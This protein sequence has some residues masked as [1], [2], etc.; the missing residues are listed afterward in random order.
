MGGVILTIKEIYKGQ[1]IRNELGIPLEAQ[2][3]LSVG[4]VN[5]N[6]NHQVGIKALAR[7][8][9][10]S[11]Y[12]VICGKGPLEESNRKLARELGVDNRV[13]FTGYRT[14]VDEFYQMADVFL[15]PSLREG[16]PVAVIEAMAS[17]LPVVATLIRGSR[18]LV[19]KNSLYRTDDIEGIS[20]A[21]EKVKKPI[22]EYGISEYDIRNVM[23]IMKEIYNSL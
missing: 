10:S 17:R 8:N 16:L 9:N 12:Y 11:S 19:N 3:I 6:K 4:E 18:D 2:V 5:K 15:F 21:M 7:L 13:I 1:K 23:E 20:K 22:T 14:D